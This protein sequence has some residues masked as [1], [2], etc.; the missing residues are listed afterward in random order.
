MK[1]ISVLSLLLLSAS[2]SANWQLD[3][4]QSGLSFLSTKNN[5]VTEISHFKS[6]NGSLSDKGELRVTIDLLSVDTKIEIRDTRMQEHLF[7]L[8]PKAHFTAQVP[9]SVLSMN[10]GETR[11]IELEGKLELNTRTKPL[12][13]LLQITRLEN[14]N[15]VATT[16][17]PVLISAIQ[18]GLADGIKKLREIA[19]L[20]SIDLIV[21]VSFNAVFSG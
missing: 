6:F 13:M 20:D 12:P 15:F 11:Q 3:Q 2:A 17:E 10:S 7:K 18:F 16:V 8:F 14:G 9:L 5:Q 4:E 21:P 19:G 1:I